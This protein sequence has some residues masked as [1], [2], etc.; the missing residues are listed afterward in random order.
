MTRAAPI[1]A[2]VLAVAGVAT[3]RPGAETGACAQDA[4][5]PRNDCSSATAAQTVER[6]AATTQSF[7]TVAV[8]PRGRRLRFAFTR[9]VNRP[10]TVDVF[11][12]SAGR[13]VLGQRRIAR[14]TG[15]TGAF[16]WNATRGSDGLYFARFA[17]RDER[18]RPDTRRVS[19]IRRNGRFAL[20]PEFYRRTSCATLTSF[21]LERPAFGGSRN[22]A[23]GIAFR[24]AREG[25]VSVEVARGSVV[26]K[27]FGPQTRRSG[28]THRLRLAPEGLRRGTYRIRLRYTGDRGSLAASLFSQR[29]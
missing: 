14:F 15:R 8:S 3:F 5:V 11:Q 10:V 24:L 25:R 12:V 7:R 20:R 19:L 6:C 29:L 27:R 21:K 26:V 13:R 28:V 16:T 23:L 2:A 4:V 18:G 22:R 9:L 17:I 1:L